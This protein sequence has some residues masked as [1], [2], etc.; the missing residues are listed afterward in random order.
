MHEPKT[1]AVIDYGKTV[2][3]SNDLLLD[4]SPIL[5]PH[6]HPPSGMNVDDV[7]ATSG[8][9]SPV[10]NHA[11]EFARHESVSSEVG[12]SDF[13]RHARELIRVHLVN[14][15][16]V[17][18]PRISG[19]GSTKVIRRL[20]FNGVA[21]VDAQGFSGGGIWVLWKACI[22]HVEVVELKQQI[23]SL[24]VTDSRGFK[25][26][27]SVVYASPTPSIRDILWN[28]LYSFNTFDSLPWL[29]VGDF[30]QIL[31]G[32]EKQWGRPEP[33]SRMNSFS[34]NIGQKESCRS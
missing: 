13:L 34:G 29:L 4:V 18:E 28:H 15:F 32:L 24:T 12:S 27:L 10:I 20:R 17:A 25:W 31:S 14:I 30:N 8:V 21:K 6:E 22:G 1:R 2:L 23:I 16:I 11:E 5:L 19:V 7:S 26:G 9:S 33:F 3:G